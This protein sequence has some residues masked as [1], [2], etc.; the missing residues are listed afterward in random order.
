MAER[1]VPPRVEKSAWIISTL[2]GVD[3]LD[4]TFSHGVLNQHENDNAVL[5]LMETILAM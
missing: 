3:F 4:K 2:F 5:E 1:S